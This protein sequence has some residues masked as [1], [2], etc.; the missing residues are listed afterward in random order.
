MRSA[1]SAYMLDAIRRHLAEEGDGHRRRVA[2][3]ESVSDL[4]ALLNPLMDAVLDAAGPQAAAE[5]ADGAAA[6][7]QRRA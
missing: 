6:I 4:L 1:L 7:L 2:R 3:A 5:F